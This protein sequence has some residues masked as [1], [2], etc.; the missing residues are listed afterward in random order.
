MNGY[1]HPNSNTYTP[2]K[3]PKPQGVTPTNG[4]SAYPIRNT[5]RKYRVPPPGEPRSKPASR[6]SEPFRKIALNPTIPNVRIQSIDDR[7]P[8]QNRLLTKR[9]K[10]ASSYNPVQLYQFLSV[11]V[12]KS[13]LERY[14]NHSP[15]PQFGNL[16]VLIIFSTGR[17]QT[18]NTDS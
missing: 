14:R 8:L 1:P 9:N 17:Y 7:E 2:Y 15:F 4:P 18:G 11:T 12:A 6:P 5:A 3:Q 16:P 10:P 13:A